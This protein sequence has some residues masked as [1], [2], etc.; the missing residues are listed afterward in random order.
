M[1]TVGCN[2]NGYAI[3]C[4]G[5]LTLLGEGCR[6]NGIPSFGN[7]AI[8]LLGNPQTLHLSIFNRFDFIVS[9]RVIVRGVYDHCTFWKAADLRCDIGDTVEGDR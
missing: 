6:T 4:T 2:W 5:R 8:K 9:K 3:G 7:W 1:I